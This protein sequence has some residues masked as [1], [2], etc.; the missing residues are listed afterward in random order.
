M[1]HNIHERIKI[2]I[3]K[4]RGST[5]HADSPRLTWLPRR[6]VQ[7]YTRFYRRLDSKTTACEKIR[8]MPNQNPIL[9]VG[10]AVACRRPGALVN[11]LE[12]AWLEGVWLGRA[13]KIEEHVIGTPKRYGSKPCTETQSG[14]TLGHSSPERNGLRPAAVDF[15][16]WRKAT[17]G[18][19][20]RETHLHGTTSKSA[21][22]LA[23]G[24]VTTTSRKTTQCVAERMRVRTAEAEAEGAPPVQRTRTA[25]TS[26]G[27]ALVED[28]QLVHMR[29]IATLMAECENT[30]PLVKLQKPPENT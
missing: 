1:V 25:A 3:E 27:R 12:S 7:Q 16:Y 20:R 24:L 14:K 30:A 23:R 5:I 2:Q 10:K 28:S 21:F 18:P 26:S 6:A 9:L 11:K 17:E 19:Q 4:N 15:G 13:S 8:H 22:Q 29:R